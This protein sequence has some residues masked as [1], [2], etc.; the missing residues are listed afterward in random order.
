MLHGV[1]GLYWYSFLSGDYR[2][3]MPTAALLF[4]GGIGA[5]AWWWVLARRLG[6]ARASTK[7]Q[8]RHR[9]SV[10]LVAYGLGCAAAALPAGISGNNQAWHRLVDANPQIASA[11][12]DT[13]L[14]VEPGIKG[15]P[16]TVYLSGFAE[17]GG[18]R[19]PYE[20]APVRFDDWDGSADLADA[21]L[22]AVFDPGNLDAGFVVVNGR[23]DAETVLEY[24]VAPLLPSGL[25]I[26]A[27]CWAVQRLLLRPWKFPERM[28][29]PIDDVP[30]WLWALFAIPCALWATGM[31]MFVA[32]AGADEPLRSSPVDSDQF[33]QIVIWLLLLMPGI[34]YFA[35]FF[36]STAANRVPSR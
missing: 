36:H 3:P 8:L 25:S 1:V 22:Q 10:L 18:V 23:S 7:A 35:A 28:L 31:A 15:D 32:Q 6:R 19:Y 9:R 12:A 2:F 14:D 11:E 26:A 27:C 17:I 24:P 16:D 21:D 30:P 33:P 13:V 5:I 29:K 4:A 34:G 20:N